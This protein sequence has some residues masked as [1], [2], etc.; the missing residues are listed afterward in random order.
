LNDTTDQAVSEEEIKSILKESAQG[1]EIQDIEHSIVERVF[2]LGD[3]KVNSLYT[4][5]SEVVF[6]REDDSLAR[7][8]SENQ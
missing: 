4:H 1:G 6:F 5:R 8:L 2:E 3:R 7:N